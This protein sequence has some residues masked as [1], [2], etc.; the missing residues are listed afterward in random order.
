MD[1]LPQFEYP[2]EVFDSFDKEWIYTKLS[3]DSVVQ[4]DFAPFPLCSS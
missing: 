2:I 3:A 1:V 4:C